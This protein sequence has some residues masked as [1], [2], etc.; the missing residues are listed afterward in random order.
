VRLTTWLGYNFKVLEVNASPKRPLEDHFHLGDDLGAGTFAKVRKVIERSTGDIYAAKMLQP[1]RTKHQTDARKRSFEREIS[2]LN[3]L[4]HRNICNMIDV[5]VDGQEHQG[6]PSLPFACLIMLTLFWIAIILEF[7]A[8][9]N[10]HQRL[11][12]CGFIGM[13]KGLYSSHA[14]KEFM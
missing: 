4:N 7:A 8:G 11:E 6:T 2:F 10:L 14:N 5:F 13:L 12:V 3:L 1:G 9:G